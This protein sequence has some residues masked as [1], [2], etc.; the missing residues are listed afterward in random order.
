MNF[1]KYLRDKL[2]TVAISFLA[3]AILAAILFL[4]K[5]N[6]V[7][8]SIVL[9]VVF[10]TF[11]I[12]FFSEFLRKSSFY[13]K[14]YEQ[15]EIIKNTDK[16]E[17]LCDVIDKPKFLDGEIMLEALSVSN[18]LLNDKLIEFGDS[19]RDYHEYVKEWAINIKN[20]IESSKSLI[21]EIQTPTAR[22]IEREIFRIDDLVNQAIFYYKSSR[23][24]NAD[25]NENINLQDLIS[26]VVRRN[27]DVLISNKIAVGIKELNHTVTTN[28]EWVEFVINEIIKNSI[29]FRSDKPC[30]KFFAQDI[31]DA[32]SLFIEDNGIGID[33]EDVPLVFEKDFVGKNVKKYT[34]SSGIGLYLCKKLCNKL[35]LKIS[36]SSDEETIVE[37]VFPKS[38]IQK[39]IA[40]GNEDID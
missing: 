12:T 3:I 30:I 27:S 29:K 1:K 19:C 16:A 9:G 34:G 14:L 25:N 6:I 24:E 5:T 28:V 23:I 13:K 2:L 15:I 10:I 40:T 37:I 20:H 26:N 21:D 7:I 31:G 32:I 18:N 11:I 4:S 36:I 17:L 8:S 38:E 35:G 33:S 39:L 22:N